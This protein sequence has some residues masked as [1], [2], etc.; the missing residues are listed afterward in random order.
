MSINADVRPSPPT[1]HVLGVPGL[2]EVEAG[3]DLAGLI[4]QAVRAVPLE[5]AARDVF[6]ISQKVVSKAEGRLV[7]LDTVEPSALARQWS[8]AFGKDPRVIELTL[9]EAVRV[10]RMDRGVL[11]AETRHGLVCANAGVDTSNVPDGWAA[12]LP[13]DPDASARRIRDGLSAALGC[14][15][16][17]IVTD[18]F[19]RPWREGQINV[20]IGLAGLSPILDYRGRTDGH[21]HRLQATAI[22]VA[23]EL[24]SAAELVMGKTRGVPVAVVKGAGELGLIIGD[25]SARDLRRRPEEDLFR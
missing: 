4:T 15:V 2:P 19:G 3:D 9:R 8:A 21:G 17:V 18:T 24:A 14:A 12:L 11:I 5:V 13:D 22:A 16:A 7:R 10:V 6:V 25:G 1:L 23:D 20:A